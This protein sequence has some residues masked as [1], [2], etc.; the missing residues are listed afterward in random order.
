MK[1]L[2]QNKRTRDYVQTDG[3]WTRR[4]E[5]AREF[6]TGL[7]AI[8]YCLNHRCAEMQILGEFTDSRMNF[9]VAV[10]DLR[11]PQA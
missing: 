6:G 11:R 1:I 10:T 8:F 7:D 4:I 3:G 9:S 2:L 5:R